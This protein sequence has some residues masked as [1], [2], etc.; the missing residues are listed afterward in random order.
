LM[1]LLI[2]AASAVIGQTFVRGSAEALIK[3]IRQTMP[4][5]GTNRFIV[6]TT[7][8]LDTW[9]IIVE[10]LKSEDFATVSSLIPPFGY[11]FFCFLDT[12][13]SDSL[14]ILKEDAP[15][16]RGWGTFIFNPRGHNDLTIEIPHAKSDTNTCIMGIR[17][18]LRL[19]ALWCIVSGT[20]R[21]T[22]TDS[23]SD[24]GHVTQSVFYKA[25][26][27]IATARALQLHGFD[28]TNPVYNGYPQLVI[29]N[30]TTSP[31]AILTALKSK[32]ELKGITAGVFSSST[33]SQL[34]RLG[35]TTNVQGQWSNANGKAFVHVEHELPVRL[36]SMRMA[37]AIEALYETFTPTNAVRQD[38]VPMKFALEQN[39]PNPFN[40]S[41]TI[42]FTFFGKESLASLIILDMLGNRVATLVDGIRTPGTHA[43]TWDASGFPTGV[44]FYKLAIGNWS[45]TRRMLLLK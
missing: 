33:Y 13:S 37:D 16:Q 12:L 27:T 23:S 15:V 22:N 19:D 43:I 17:G 39:Y 18:M 31:P 44:Y 29:S 21:Y 6:P 40:P 7:P 4:G 9:R 30:G 10:E 26:Q 14:Y 20:H 41:T 11:S 1:L 36:D 34:W 28:R 25:H 38:D 2:T 32:Y 5:V 45:M 42:Q 3:E 35:A 24:M 8:Q